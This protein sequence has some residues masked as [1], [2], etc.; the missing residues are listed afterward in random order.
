MQLEQ[1]RINVQSA[2]DS[3]NLLNDQIAN[4]TITAPV[5]GLVM[6]RS[7]DP[8]DIVNPSTE[9]LSLARLNDLTITVYIP[10]ES[11]GNIKLGETATVGMDAFPG[12]TFTGAVVYISKQPEFL[13]RTTQ[14]VSASKSTVYAVQLKLNDATGKVKSGMPADVTFVLK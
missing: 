6:T 13:P 10:E 4:T 9:L 8:G 14:T 1:A 12:E 7:V 2:Q 11:Y 5:D 3:L